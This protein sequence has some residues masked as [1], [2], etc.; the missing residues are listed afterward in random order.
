MTSN[1]DQ[2][3]STSPLS[4]SRRGFVKTG[5]ALFVS[6]AVPLRFNG[7]ADAAEGATSIDPTTVASWLEIRSDNTIVARTGRTETGVGSSRRSRAPAGTKI[8]Q[9]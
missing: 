3:S 8:R 7:R 2:R 9:A 4:I 6:L 5:G 1:L